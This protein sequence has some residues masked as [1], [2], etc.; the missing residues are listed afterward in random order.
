[1][2]YLIVFLLF[3]G[4]AVIYAQN[5]TDKQRSEALSVATKFCDLLAQYSSNGEQFLNN[6][7]KIFDLCTSQ[8]ITAYNDLDG[9]NEDL[10]VSY[11]FTILGKYDNKLGMSFTPLKIDES[12]GIPVFK[13]KLVSS[14]RSIQ[15]VVEYSD[16]YI[17]MSTKQII[18][19]LG[20]QI[21]RKIIYSCNEN[22]VIAF[23]ISDSPFV[24][25]QKA[26]KAFAFK[27][28]DSVPVFVDKVLSHERI[29]PSMKNQ[30]STIALK[31]AY[32]FKSLEKVRK[33]VTQANMPMYNFLRGRIYHS[34]KN[35][36]DALTYY[37]LA[38]A[39][40][41]DN[42]NNV[43][44]NL[45]LTKGTAYYDIKKAKEYLEQG[46][47]SKNELVV[48][49]C[50]YTYGANALLLPTEF[51]LSDIQIIPY[52][53]R[54]AKSGY[55]RSFL[56]LSILYENVGDKPS[57]SI[58]DE[59]SADAGSNIGKARYGYYLL[60]SSN[61]DLRTKGLTYLREASTAELDQELTLL[62]LETGLKPL[63]PKSADQIK[64]LIKKYNL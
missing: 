43:L 20:K 9:N 37:E 6:D 45:Y 53:E 38:A 44:G 16:I 17:I 11:L 48:S 49:M 58:W 33:Y 40:G 29:D 12:F 64:Q 36:K 4:N 39:G 52:F 2:K 1:M 56:P 61:N 5:V 15:E 60:S 25:F 8:N 34:Q 32:D 46:M 3:F 51:S 57:A 22:K 41:Y 28:Y 18:N 26:L 30:A 27:D 19:T 54:S 55:L 24:S 42:A 7:S 35:M 59:K 14:G 31:S 10:L 63:F 13:E 62:W 50:S 47:K 23:I 21:D